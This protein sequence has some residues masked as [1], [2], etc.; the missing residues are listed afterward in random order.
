MPNPIENVMAKGAGKV[1]AVEARAKGLKGVFTKLVEQH[2]EAATLLSRAQSTTD[3]EKRRDLWREIKKQLVSHE[4]AELSEIYPTLSA[5]D[6]TRDIVGRH[7]QEANVL[8]TN[9]RQIDAMTFDAPAWKPSI[10]RLIELVKQ[11]VDEEEKDFFPRAQAALGDEA[12]KQLEE[13]FMRAKQREM[14]AV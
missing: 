6:S 1:G 4:R 10:E 11:H 9:I 8:E 14:N 2:R 12:S 3:V 5:Y 7:A 13:P